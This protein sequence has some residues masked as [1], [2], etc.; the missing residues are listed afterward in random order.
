MKIATY[1]RKTIEATGMS[2]LEYTKDC[3]HKGLE[4]SEAVAMDAMTREEREEYRA[5]KIAYLDELL[6]DCPF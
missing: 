1:V 2:I 5:Y 4:F 3:L 6:K